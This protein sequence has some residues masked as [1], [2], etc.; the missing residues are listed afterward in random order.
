MPMAMRGGRAR[1]KSP[2]PTGSTSAMKAD[3]KL[4]I[5]MSVEPSRVEQPQQQ[6]FT[7]HM[8]ADVVR[9]PAGRTRTDGLRNY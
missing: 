3:T 9:W 4:T 7:R 5:P 1:R 2:F 6:L 8:A